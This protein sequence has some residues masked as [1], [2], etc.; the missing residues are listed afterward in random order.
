MGGA[1]ECGDARE[2]AAPALRVRP[3][4][5]YFTLVSKVRQTAGRA[6]LLRSRGL[7][8]QEARQEPRPTSV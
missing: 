8:A 4:G 3:E 5:G 2:A 7:L 6:T 1:A